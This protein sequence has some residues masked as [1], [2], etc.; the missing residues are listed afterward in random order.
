MKLLEEKIGYQLQ[1][2]Y[3]LDKKIGGFKVGA[4]NYRSSELFN[5]NCILLGAIEEKSVFFNSVEKDYPIAEVEVIS[6][7]KIENINER[8]FVVKGHYLGI[9]CPTINVDNPHNS[10]FICLADN[11]SAGD[12]IIL[13]ELDHIRFNSINLFIN[14]DLICT[15][16]YD[17][18]RFP[19]SQILEKTVTLIKN[20]NLL[21]DEK[22]IFIATGGLTE[23]FTLVKG[24]KISIKINTK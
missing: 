21:D 1:K 13:N 2:K 19:I 12:L 22:E 7:I 18:M 16:G 11:C 20:N 10:P 14:D 3:F 6:K 4:S 8:L 9:E 23:T 24:D 5:V 15:G 17:N